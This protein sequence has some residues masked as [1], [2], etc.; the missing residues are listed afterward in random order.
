MADDG[1]EEKK[2]VAK[3]ELER[4]TELRFEVEA[5]QTVQLE[6]LT[7]MAEVFG[8]E[9]TR[10]KKFTF[11]AGAKV[12]VF[13]WHGCTVQL[14]GRTEVA[15]VSRD[16]PML[17]YLNTHTALEQMRRQAEREDERGPRV[18]VVGPTDVGKT[19][20]CRL[21]LNYAVR[22]GRRPTFVELDVGQG[23]V[24]IP[25]TMGALYIERP[26]DVEEGFSLQAPLVY[27]FGST[28]PGTNIKLYNKITSCLADVFNQRCEV[29]RRASV[30]GCV[31]NT[32][33]WVKSSGYQALVHAASAF[34][35]DVVV[36]LDQERLYNELKRDL[37]HFVRTVLLPKSGGV[38]ERSKDFRR[39]CR[40]ER[41]R[42]QPAEAGAG[43][44]GA[45][46]GA[47][48]AERQHRR[49][50]R[51]QH[52]RDQRGR[53]HRGHRRGPGAPGLHRAVPGPTPPSQEL[54]AHHGHSL[55]GPQVGEGWDVPP[56]SSSLCPPLVPTVRCD[57]GAAPALRFYT[58]CTICY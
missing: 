2:Q 31:I 37:P 8:T 6:L 58:F 52:L 47:P 22:L 34:E 1:G 54:P 42:G 15:Y 45:G 19:T 13:T 11:D 29:N 35:V 24:S 28:T 16:T 25:G 9:L 32:C 51:R 50:P 38:V 36:V 33:G 14:S 12:A 30:S 43:D 7:G 55:H 46:H 49:Q 10:N 56:V 39:E 5:G 4:E 40:D 20:V 53:L 41:I 23:S 21:L 27:H 17:L 44:A 3:F 18:M 48:P 26:A 57:P